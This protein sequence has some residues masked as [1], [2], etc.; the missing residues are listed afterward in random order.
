MLDFISSSSDA[1]SC[2]YC[3]NLLRELGHS[4]A[5]PD[6]VLGIIYEVA[7]ESG[8]NVTAIYKGKF[9]MFYFSFKV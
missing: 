7:T 8:N 2:I 1:L 9:F 6:E 4:P 5:N 3:W